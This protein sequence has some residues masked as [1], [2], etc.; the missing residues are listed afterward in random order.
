[1]SKL[2]GWKRI[3]N[4]QITDSLS[5]SKRKPNPRPS[6]IQ[7]QHFPGRIIGLCGLFLSLPLAAQITVMNSSFEFNFSEA[8]PHYGS[9]D[10]WDG[11]S[12]TNLQEGPFHNGGTPIPDQSQVVFLQGSRTLTQEVFGLTP[13]SYTHLTLPTK[14][15]V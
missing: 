3:N 7:K 12:G 13:V 4:K 10:E 8:W 15:I 1:M 14:R 6:M 5:E 2:T 11:G 9:V